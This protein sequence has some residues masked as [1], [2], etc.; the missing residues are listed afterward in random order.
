MKD[1][2]IALKENAVAMEMLIDD[3]PEVMSLKFLL[4]LLPDDIEVLPITAGTLGSFAV[5]LVPADLLD[6]DP[7]GEAFKNDLERLMDDEA[8]MIDAAVPGMES[9]K[10]SMG[11]AQYVNCGGIKT[12]LY[13]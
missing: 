5:A 10:E 1:I 4:N 6:N 8:E 9:F 2:K 13:C 3:Y 12:L 11:A 7:D